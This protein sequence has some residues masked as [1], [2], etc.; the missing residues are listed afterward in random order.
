MS[1]PRETLFG[2]RALDRFDALIIGSGPSGAT[3][4]ALL[5]RH[6][7]RVLI[8]EAGGNYYAGLDDPRPGMPVPLLGNDELK[9]TR[10]LFGTSALIAPRS[11][12]PDAAAGI[13]TG[14]DT[15]FDLPRAVGGGSV[16]ADGRL[17][18][19]G[20]QDF[21]LGTLLK[22]SIPGADYADWP[23]SYDELEPYYSYLE[24]NVG[25]Q[26]EADPN[27]GRRSAPYPM[28]PGPA[29][30]VSNL[31][32]EAARKRGYQ[33]FRCPR[34]VNSRPYGGHPACVNCGFC[35]GFG[36]PIN[37]RGG[38]SAVTSLRAALLSGSCLLMSET[39]VLRL[40]ISPATRQVEGVDVT[41]SDGRRE[42]LRADRYIL[43]TGAV[44]DAR[45]VLLSD[46]DGVANPRDLVGRNFCGRYLTIA[47][48][49]FEHRVHQDRGNGASFSM[50]D[51]RGVAGDSSRPLGGLVTLG[52]EQ[53]PLGEAALYLNSLKV[54]PGP[55]LKKALRQ[56]IGRERMAYMTMYGEDPPQAQNRVDLDPE[57]RDHN[58]LPAARITYRRHAYGAASSQLYSPRLL[59]LLEL[60]GARYGTILPLDDVSGQCGHYG[61]T[62]RAGRDPKQSVCDPTGRFHTVG[63]LYA[64]G[65]SL[66]ASLPGYNPTLTM[67]A[68][69]LRV[70]AGFINPTSPERSL[71]E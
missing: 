71:D 4:A 15:Y 31:L 28:T 46:P 18:R 43:A 40:M 35:A 60:A 32:A 20:P 29:K 45:L 11:Y 64:A 30:Y 39:R 19:F 5:C 54:Q 57:L 1:A 49:I 14:I 26:G 48:G 53:T 44:E 27:G 3:A 10:G 69:A 42:V 12:R 2:N 41:R 55:L 65:G 7:K 66:F 59:D 33:P 52:G 67:M 25:L 24:Q 68:L 63:N 21:Q 50:T 56:G 38:S 51:L 8:V 37:A 70:A 34:G 22:G 16:L 9:G 13:R 6:G 23:I 47:V 58:G 61:G 36:C 62:L 17:P